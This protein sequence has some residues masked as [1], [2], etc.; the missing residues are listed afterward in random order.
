VMPY[1]DHS[2]ELILPDIVAARQHA[3]AGM[4][5]PIAGTHT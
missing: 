5:P 1:D 3:A 2:H 4:W